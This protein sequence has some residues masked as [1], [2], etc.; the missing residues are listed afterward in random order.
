MCCN[1]VFIIMMILSF[2]SN[3]FPSLVSSLSTYACCFFIFILS[4]WISDLWYFY[5]H[6]CFLIILKF[7]FQGCSLFP[8]EYFISLKSYDSHSVFFLYLYKW[9]I[10]FSIDV[11]TLA[12]TGNSVGAEVKMENESSGFLCFLVQENP[13]LLVNNVTFL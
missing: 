3:S 6:N 9:W 2:Y 1:A 4:F 12:I 13:F 7:V 8:F 11:D 5:I 10:P